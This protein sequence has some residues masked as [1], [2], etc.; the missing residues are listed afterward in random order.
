MRMSL[1][2]NL[3]LFEPGGCD[4]KWFSNSYLLVFIDINPRSDESGKS[5]LFMHELLDFLI[6]F[7]KVSPFKLI[8]VSKISYKERKPSISFGFF[9]LDF[10][11]FI[12][13]DSIALNFVCLTGCIEFIGTLFL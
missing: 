7:S 6:F 13:F 5:G 4:F 12:F 10:G 3:A 11:F 9:L 8:E 1:L 2:F